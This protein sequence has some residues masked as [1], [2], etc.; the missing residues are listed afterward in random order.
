MFFGTLQNY[1]VRL[2]A[3]FSEI[4]DFNKCNYNVII[5]VLLRIIFLFLKS[6]WIILINM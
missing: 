5:F 4:Y 2:K 3:D 6:S 1:K